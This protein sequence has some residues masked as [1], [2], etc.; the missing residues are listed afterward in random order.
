MR[1]G[2]FNNN[3]E[4]ILSFFRPPKY[5]TLGWTSFTLNMLHKNGHFWTT[6]PPHLVHIV[7][8]RPP[9]SRHRG[10]I[11]MKREMLPAVSYP[12]VYAEYCKMLCGLINLERTSKCRFA[13]TQFLSSKLNS[14]YFENK[15]STVFHCHIYL[16]G[17]NGWHNFSCEVFT[18]SDLKNP[19]YFNFSS[20]FGDFCLKFFGMQSNRTKSQS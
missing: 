13:W 9:G 1:Q 18:R 20:F 19:N 11:R 12:I 5:L 3:V 8:E 6:Y 16:P 2:S 10:L 7:I 14:N 4:M 17:V 15:H